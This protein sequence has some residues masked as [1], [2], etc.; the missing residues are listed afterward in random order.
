MVFTTVLVL[1]QGVLIKLFDE[2]VAHS[3]RSRYW[4]N[5]GKFDLAKSVTVQTPAQKP[6]IVESSPGMCPDELN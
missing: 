4:G 5:L 6:E 3:R 2:Q 1:R